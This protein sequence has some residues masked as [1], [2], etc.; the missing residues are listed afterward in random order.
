MTRNSIG[1]ILLLCLSFVSVS[2]A[3]LTFNYAGKIQSVSVPDRSHLSEAYTGFKFPEDADW[4]SALITK[5]DSSNSL[6]SVQTNLLQNLQNLAAQWHDNPAL[7]KSVQQM[8]TLVEKTPVA[9]RIQAKLD[10]DWVLLRQEFNPQLE[11]NYTLYLAPYTFKLQLAGLAGNQT[12]PIHEGYQLTDYL[13]DGSYQEGADKD[14]V[15]LI[16][17]EGQ[18]HKMPVALWNRVYSEPSSGSMIFVGFESSLLPDNM[19]DLNEQI[20]SY[21]ANRIPQ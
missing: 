8:M 20:A 17:P 9:L 18:W 4:S 12:L 15:Y 19:P 14:F 2:A 3:E 10:P 5:N 7:V 13:A 16:V 6:K 1:F 21:L 11:G